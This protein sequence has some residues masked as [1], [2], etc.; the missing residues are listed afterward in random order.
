[1][2]AGAPATS[3]K[4]SRLVEAICIHLA[5]KH[6]QPKKER[7]DTGKTIYTSRWKLILADYHGI[8]ARLLNSSAL[9]KDTDL[10]LFHINETTLTRWYKDTVRM[11]EIRTLLQGFQIPAQ[12]PAK[13]NE[14]LPAARVRPSSPPNLVIEPFSFPDPVDTTG[15]ARVRNRTS[16]LTSAPVLPSSTSSSLPTAV[17]ETLTQVKTSRTTDW[18]KRK[19]EAEGR[20]PVNNEARKVYTCRVC[21]KPMSSEGHTQFRG[22]RYCPHAPGQVPREQWL[23]ER[24]AEAAAN[25][26]AKAKSD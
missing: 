8:R 26:Q 14:P 22:K 1:M 20:A 9:L 2:S 18:R 21:K 10:V 25:A 15:Q 12:P 17:P 24:K 5:E 13:A 3:P 23:Q 6:P 11:E 4:Q 16:P 7:S 19:A